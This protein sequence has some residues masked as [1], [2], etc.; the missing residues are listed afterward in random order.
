[1]SWACSVVFR[2]LFDSS[3]WQESNPEVSWELVVIVGVC[4]GKFKESFMVCAFCWIRLL[5]HCFLTENGPSDY[6]ASIHLIWFIMPSAEIRRYDFWVIQKSYAFCRINLH[7]SFCSVLPSFPHRLMV[8]RSHL[9][10]QARSQSRSLGWNEP[11]CVVWMFL[12]QT[13]SSYCGGGLIIDAMTDC[14]FFCNSILF[15]TP[16]LPLPCLRCPTGFS[17]SL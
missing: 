6:K 10:G 14:K 7:T 5:L 2:S 15:C 13:V 12:K 9:R 1:M 8:R 3:D 16:A 11:S 4:A 17:P